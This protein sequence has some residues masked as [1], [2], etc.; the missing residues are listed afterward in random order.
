[1]NSSF[2]AASVLR[3]SA[4][5]IMA[6]ERFGHFVIKKMCLWRSRSETAQW[7]GRGFF[8]FGL[9]ALSGLW[10]TTL[11]ADA[12]VPITDGPATTYARFQLTFISNFT[13]PIITSSD[14]A[15]LV[16]GQYFSYTITA[17]GNASFF[18]Y[19]GTD[20]VLNGRLPP[21]LHY[22]PDTHIISGI[23][24]G[25]SASQSDTSGAVSLI[26]RDGMISPD[27]TIRPPLIGILQL[28]AG[29]DNGAG[30]SPLNF[31]H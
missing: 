28:I 8:L 1:M 31:T 27:R 25:G 4:T 26:G 30:T 21:D 12:Q 11:A 15:T 17:E 14:R 7:K 19:I 20:G 10:L 16:P 22:H 24:R 23:Y 5:T 2:R 9:A 6:S 13:V 18:G 29:N 3:Y